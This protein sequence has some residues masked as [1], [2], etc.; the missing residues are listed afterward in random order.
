[1]PMI[2]S[3]TLWSSFLFLEIEHELFELQNKF[4][5]ELLRQLRL[6]VGKFSIDNIIKVF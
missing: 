2:Y 1:M 6:I 5:P 4:W 3:N